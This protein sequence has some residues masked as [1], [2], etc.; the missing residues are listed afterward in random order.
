MIHLHRGLAENSFVVMVGTLGQGDAGFVAIKTVY[1][2]VRRC[3]CILNSSR[4]MSRDDRTNN[5]DPPIGETY[6]GPFVH[7]FSILFNGATFS[8]NYKV[9]L[10]QRRLPRKTCVRCEFYWSIKWYNRGYGSKPCG[11]PM[12]RA[13][14]RY[15]NEEELQTAK[16]NAKLACCVILLVCLLFSKKKRFAKYKLKFW[17]DVDAD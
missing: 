14:K 5:E 15:G 7:V 2:Y 17:C 10:C 1:R 9:M 12:I 6:L 3:I 4:W 11:T 8:N 16:R 13:G